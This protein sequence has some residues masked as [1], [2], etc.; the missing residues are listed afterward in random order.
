MFTVVTIDKAGRIVLPKPVR[1]ELQLSPGDSLEVDSSEERV[2][3]RPVRGSSRIYKKQG[4]WV[5]HG[6]APLSEDVVEKTMQ[7]VRREREQGF[8]GKQK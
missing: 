7:Q 2:I 5:M 1:D 6:G 8:L 4:V 3:L